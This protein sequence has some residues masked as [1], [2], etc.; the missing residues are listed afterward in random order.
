MRYTNISNQLLI[1]KN[2]IFFSEGTG[3]QKRCLDH[4]HNT[5]RYLDI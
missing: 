2:V 3:K 1:V 4:D 5:K